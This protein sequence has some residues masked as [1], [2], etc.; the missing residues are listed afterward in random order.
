[1]YEIDFHIITKGNNQVGIMVSEQII[2]QT[3]ILVGFYRGIPLQ[4]KCLFTVRCTEKQRSKNI[5]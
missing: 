1:M 3:T 2:F 4:F 5:W